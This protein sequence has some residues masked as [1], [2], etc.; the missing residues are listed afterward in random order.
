MAARS[1]TAKSD[2]LF[3]SC[4]LQ[5]REEGSEAE[6]RSDMSG[7]SNPKTSD[8]AA[9]DQHVT[10]RLAEFIVARRFADLSGDTI[11]VAKQCLLD[12]LGVAL[13]ARNEPAVTKLL[14]VEIEGPQTGRAS[15]IGHSC[16]TARC[17]RLSS[18][19]SWLML[20][21]SMT[22][23]QPC[24]ATRPAAIAPAVLALGEAEGASGKNVLLAFAAGV[25]VACL[26]GRVLGPDHYDMGFHAS[27][28]LGA[29]GAAALARNS[30]NLDCV[31]VAEAIGLAATQAAGL[32]AVFGTMAKPL[33][34]G[35][36]AQSGLLSAQLARQGFSA[37]QDAIERDQG[38]A[39]THS[40]RTAAKTFADAFGEVP[41]LDSVSFKYHVSCFLTHA[42]IEAVLLLKRQHRID[43]GTSMGS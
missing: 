7:R 14:A 3:E 13:A 36:A 17:R 29:L 15:V 43:P 30:L 25:D 8:A 31:T 35:K 41:F 23:I 27:G 34:V 21:A 11:N 4:C 42:M 19:V 33:N 40:P 24:A 9:S 38:F 22:F 37:P 6:R 2:P 32:K 28:T 1:A 39:G 5:L 12:V 10:S 26:L 16:A 20:S 18:M